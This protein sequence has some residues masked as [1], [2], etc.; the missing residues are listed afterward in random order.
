[1]KAAEQAQIP[2]KV[3]EQA[4]TPVKPAVNVRNSIILVSPPDNMTVKRGEEVVFT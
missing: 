2:V 3:A 4:K 1:V